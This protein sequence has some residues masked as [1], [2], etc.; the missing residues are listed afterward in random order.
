MNAYLPPP[1]EKDPAFGTQ[2]PRNIDWGCATHLRTGL[3]ARQ[4]ILMPC[5][6]FGTSSKGVG[7]RRCSPGLGSRGRWETRRFRCGS[8]GSRGESRGNGIFL[9]CTFGI[10]CGQIVLLN[11]RVKVSWHL[12]ICRLAYL[13]NP[14]CRKS[15]SGTF[16]SR[17]TYSR[18]KDEGVACNGRGSTEIRR[19]ISRIPAGCSFYFEDMTLDT[20]LAA[21]PQQCLCVRLCL[22][23]VA[24]AILILQGGWIAHDTGKQYIMDKGHVRVRTTTWS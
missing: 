5:R 17:D 21:C 8:G 7:G 12:E 4:C 24:C 18:P 14:V 6:D 9:S 22:G 20:E 10:L 19:R 3:L 16:W 2:R 13:V 11:L 23:C 15:S 1:R